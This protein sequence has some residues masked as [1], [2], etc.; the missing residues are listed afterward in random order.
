[1]FNPFR[2]TPPAPP[3]AAFSSP[4][5]P[6]LTRCAGPGLVRVP[7][8]ETSLCAA[9]HV[10]PNRPKLR[11]RVLQFA[12]DAGPA[13]FTD[14]ELVLFDPKAPESS[15]RKRRTELTERNWIIEAGFTRQ[16]R[17]G[18]AMKVWLHRKFVPNAPMILSNAD[19]KAAKARWTPEDERAAVVAYL[20]RQTVPLSALADEIA[21]GDHLKTT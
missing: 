19:V 3:S 12:A 14:E 16:N 5:H 2:K 7:D 18:E 1:M 21:A 17:H 15:L 6:D 9:A 4:T 13:G 20:Q 10:D 8:H 11:A